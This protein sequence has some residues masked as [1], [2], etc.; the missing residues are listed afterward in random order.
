MKNTPKWKGAG[1]FSTLMLC[2]YYTA[3]ADIMKSAAGAPI[4]MLSEL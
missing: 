2:E 3:Y 4:L 1:M